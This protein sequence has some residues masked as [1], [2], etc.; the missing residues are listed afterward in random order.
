MQTIRQTL[1]P[2]TN[3]PPLKLHKSDSKKSESPSQ[4]Q[5]HPEQVDDRLMAR[6]RQWRSRPCQKL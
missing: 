5:L 4:P 3:L 6:K 1:K 2:L